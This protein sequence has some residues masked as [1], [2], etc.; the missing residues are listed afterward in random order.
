MAWKDRFDY[1]RF[2]WT[3][4]SDYRYRFDERQ[5]QFLKDVIESG[6]GRVE[7][8]EQN[9]RLWRAQKGSQAQEHGDLNDKWF[10]DHI[11]SR[12]RALHASC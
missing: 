1:D 8:W 7:E 11:V 9:K 3:V 12:I 6:R 5:E 4:K 10:P 2:D